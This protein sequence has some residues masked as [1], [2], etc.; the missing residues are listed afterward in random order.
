M[1]VRRGEKMNETSFKLRNCKKIGKKRGSASKFCRRLLA[2]SS[3]SYSKVSGHFTHIPYFSGF[4]SLIIIQINGTQYF[5]LGLA[6][7]ISNLT[8][9]WMLW[10]KPGLMQS[11]IRPQNWNISSKVSVL[12][13]C[14]GVGSD[15][16]KDIDP[17]SSSNPKGVFD[18][19]Q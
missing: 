11:K 19:S 18:I 13:W 15:G 17:Q 14:Q 1:W 4:I 6:Q 16:H 5:D 3:I 12:G 10:K 9:Y 7:V 2:A 8:S